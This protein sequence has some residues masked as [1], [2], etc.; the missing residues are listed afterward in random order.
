MRK[1]KSERALSKRSVDR[2]RARLE[3]GAAALLA[4]TLGACGSSAPRRSEV[5]PPR[6]AVA[7]TRAPSVATTAPSRSELPAPDV[8]SRRTRR[9]E[10]RGAEAAT[11]DEQEVDEAIAEAA[12]A[13]HARALA[14]MRAENW[15]EAELE[16]E[17]LTLEYPTYPGPH[18]NLALVYLED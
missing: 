12:S 17:Q 14:A 13:A 2:R 4:L 18:V 1:R 5:A 16:L 15:L 11:S 7:S 3:A 9:S 6:E 10:R 8:E